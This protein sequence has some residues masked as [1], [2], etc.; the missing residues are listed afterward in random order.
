MPS[1]AHLL[2]GAKTASSAFSPTDISGCVLWLD[3]DDAATITEA[4]G[5]ISQWDD[6][7]GN[8]YDVTQGTAANKPSND[9]TRNSRTTIYFDGG[10]YLSGSISVDPSNC[11]VFMAWATDGTPGGNYYGS[12]SL[13]AA[14]G[15]DWNSADGISVNVGDENYY[16]E[17]DHNGAPGPRWSGSGATPWHVA[18]IVITRSAPTVKLYTDGTLRDTAANGG[19]AGAATTVVVGARWLSGAVSTSYPLTGDVGEII[20]YNSPLSDAD[21]ATVEDYLMTKWGL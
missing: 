14:G 4:S 5:E 7:S 12:L 13:G 19:V 9:G 16:T 21:R 18:S 17:I 15:N 2:L 10:D 11:T 3:A 20:I 8:G 6:K 1:P